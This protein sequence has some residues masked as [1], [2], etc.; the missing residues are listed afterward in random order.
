[1]VSTRPTAAITTQG[2][3]SPF[4]GWS[5]HPTASQCRNESA[6]SSGEI[7]AVHFAF[8]AQQAVLQRQ[9]W[10]LFCS[11]QFPDCHTGGHGRS[12]HRWHCPDNAKQMDMEILSISPRAL[13]MRCGEPGPRAP[14]AIVASRGPGLFRREEV[15]PELRTTEEEAALIGRGPAPME[16]SANANATAR[17]T[18]T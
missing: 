15:L 11:P 1:M 14:V 12:R 8:P 16:R 5:R 4:E 9:A 13:S 2:C 10:D 17:Q 6:G 7:E 18:P 3:R